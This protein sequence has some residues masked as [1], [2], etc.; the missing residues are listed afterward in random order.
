MRAALILMGGPAVPDGPKLKAHGVT[1]LYYEAR[2]PQVTKES[3]DMLRK[4][5]FEVGIDYDPGWDND[6][7]PARVAQLIVAH[8][9]R[10]GG[11]G[12]QMAVMLDMEVHNAVYAEAILREFR[13]LQPG[14]NIIWT[15]ES[16]QAGWFDPSLVALINEYSQLR[17]APQ[18][19]GGDMTPFAGDQ[20]FKDLIVHGVSAT[21]LV[22]FYG[23]RDQHWNPV[24]IPLWWDGIL[25]VESMSQL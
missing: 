5:G 18:F 8:L 17:V 12:A 23:L 24:L 1:R 25:Y 21:R 4:A 14:R 2:D 22:G 3:L 10:L 13:K 11:I 19:Y 20:A 6:P 7:S 16:E 9:K 15:L